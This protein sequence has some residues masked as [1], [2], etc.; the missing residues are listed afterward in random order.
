[1]RFLES[2]TEPAPAKFQFG[3][4]LPG[5]DLFHD[6]ESLLVAFLLVPTAHLFHHGRTIKASV[7]ATAEF[8]DH[9]GYVS[10]TAT[11]GFKTV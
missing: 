6:N 9:L 4:L 2:G 7:F 5:K 1:L 10:R 3:S 11:R 8:V